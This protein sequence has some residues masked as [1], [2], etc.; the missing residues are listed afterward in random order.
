MITANIARLLVG[1]RVARRESPAGAGA[2]ASE[3]RFNGSGR[4]VLFACYPGG[5]CRRGCAPRGVVAKLT[6]GA[7]QGLAARRGA[8]RGGFKQTAAR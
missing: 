4:M 5:A 6:P 7:G 1:L 3:P 8:D 2:H